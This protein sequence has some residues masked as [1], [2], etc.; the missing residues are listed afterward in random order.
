M[1]K[2]SK[3]LRYVEELFNLK[4]STWVGMFSV[5]MLYKIW[6]GGTIGGDA[7]TIYGLVLTNFVIN[8]TVTAFKG[9]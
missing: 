3:C 2:L 7:I 1:S 5:T 6:A 9:E 8:K 4:G